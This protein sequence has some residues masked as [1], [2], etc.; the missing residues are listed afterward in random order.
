M[1]LVVVLIGILTAMIIP[2][3]KGSYEDVL[4]RSTSRELLNAF[5]LASSRSVCLNQSHRVRLDRR[6]GRYFVEKRV[7]KGSRQPDFVPLHDVAGAEGDL[8]TRITIQVRQQNEGSAG[9]PSAASN[10]PAPLSEAA[11][12]GV[13]AP[14][15]IT[16]YPDGTADAAE[17]L[18]RDRAGF[19]LVLRVN[20]ITARVRVLDLARAPEPK[21]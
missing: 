17:L 15:T 11:A 13:T 10:L 4:L 6:A 5:N 1:M 7:H 2:E 18:L 20:P 14:D 16:F 9:E 19:Q 8:D 21:P 3:M 12:S